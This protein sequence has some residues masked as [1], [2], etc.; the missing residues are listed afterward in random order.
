MEG[1][2]TMKVLLTGAFGNFGTTTLHNLLEQGHEVR[3]FD[4]L[5]K[6]NRKTASKFENRI[7]TI[8][9]DVRSPDDLA[10]AVHDR[11]VVIHLAFIVDMLRSD[12]QPEWA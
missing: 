6:A 5:T 8:W 10:L 7:E 9:G 11:D 1:K 2:K 12:E 4:L 3:C